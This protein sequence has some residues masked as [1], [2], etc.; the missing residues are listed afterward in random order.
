MKNEISFLDLVKHVII[1]GL[2]WIII[3]TIIFALGGFFYGHAIYVPQYSATTSVKIYHKIKPIKKAHKTKREYKH[4]IKKAE[5]IQRKK[6]IRKMDK[7]AELVVDQ[8]N[9][10]IVIKKLRKQ[11]VDISIERLKRSVSA[12]PKNND[13]ALTISSTTKKKSEPVKI[14][15]TVAD[16][17]TDQYDY[18][19]K[20]T[21]VIHFEKAKQVSVNTP[22][23]N[24]YT[25]RGVILGIIL[26]YILTIIFSIRNFKSL[27]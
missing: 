9:L 10:K 22:L 2:P 7:N 16:V 13:D 17:F 18:S 27:N 15:N 6:D 21:R 3:I 12:L 19:Q 14:V 4:A 23:T 5:K 1:K 20:R 8:K 24:Y 25:I 11:N 26:G